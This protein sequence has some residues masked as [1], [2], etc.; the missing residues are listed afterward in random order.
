MSLSDAWRFTVIHFAL[1]GI[2]A[3]TPTPVSKIKLQTLTR[4]PGGI[5]HRCAT[6][7]YVTRRAW[8]I[9]PEIFLSS[10]LLK[11]LAIISFGGEAQC[12]ASVQGTGINRCDFKRIHVHVRRAFQTRMVHIR[13]YC[14]HLS[15]LLRAYAVQQAD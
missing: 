7:R 1:V 14:C 10:G 11:S 9:H 8:T 12:Q 2:L 13:I 5:C 4:V 3:R 6:K 15:P